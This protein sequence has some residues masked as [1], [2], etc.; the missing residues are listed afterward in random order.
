MLHLCIKVHVFQYIYKKKKTL[1][2]LKNEK[3]KMVKKCA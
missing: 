3:K 2:C 1:L